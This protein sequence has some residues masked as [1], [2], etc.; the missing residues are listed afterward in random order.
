MAGDTP[1]RGGVTRS[2]REVCLP[3]REAFPTAT[4]NTWTP[5]LC[6]T[7]GL[8]RD[9]EHVDPA[10]SWRDPCGGGYA[11][12][13]RRHAVTAG[14]VPPSARSFPRR[15]VEHVDPAATSNTW[16]PPRRRTGGPRRDVEHVDPAASWRDPCGGGCVRSRR[17]RA[18]T[19]GGVPPS[20]RSFPCR[21]VEHVV[22]AAM[23]NMWTPPRRHRVVPAGGGVSATMPYGLRMRTR[24]SAKTTSPNSTVK[25]AIAML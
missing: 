15:D 6:R 4:S 12:S 10:A 5:P 20:A 14:G 1:A 22:P 21:N 13:R 2:R 25:T 17:R 19:A 8:R 9:V 3:P 23:S 16:T 11:R 18:V 7:G 24:L